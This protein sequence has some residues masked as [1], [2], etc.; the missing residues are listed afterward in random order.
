M[1]RIA[2]IYNEHQSQ[3]VKGKE[4]KKNNIYYNIKTTV[5]RHFDDNMAVKKIDLNV[6]LRVLIEIKIT[7]KCQD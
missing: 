1:E 3:K 5:C 6:Y 4:K 2:L 7:R